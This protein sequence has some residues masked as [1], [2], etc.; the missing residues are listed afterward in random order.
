MVNVWVLEFFNIM[1]L[2]EKK[3]VG[4]SKGVWLVTESREGLGVNFVL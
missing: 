1:R 3:L 2:G 4:E